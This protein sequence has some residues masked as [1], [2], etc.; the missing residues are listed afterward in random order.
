MN[1]FQAR[2]FTADLTLYIPVHSG[3]SSKENV[4][5]RHQFLHMSAP[6]YFWIHHRVYCKQFA[7]NIRQ[8]TPI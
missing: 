3:P 4:L 1:I 5:A 7:N 2:L 6:M 8:G